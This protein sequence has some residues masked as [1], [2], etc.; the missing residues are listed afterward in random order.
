MNS[1]LSADAAHFIEGL[2]HR[3]HT[4]LRMKQSLF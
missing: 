3:E 2:V 1:D 4:T